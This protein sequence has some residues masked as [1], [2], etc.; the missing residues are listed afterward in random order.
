MSLIFRQLAQEL[1]DSN[2]LPM[3]HA[4]IHPQRY[5]V[6]ISTECGKPLTELNGVQFSRRSPTMAEINYAV[7]LLDAFLIKHGQTIRDA[8]KVHFELKDLEE[9]PPIKVIGYGD[10]YDNLE[11]YAHNT[12][13]IWKPK[14]KTFTV[15]FWRKSYE[16]VDNAT[17]DTKTKITGVAIPA[18]IKSKVRE[19]FK[20]DFHVKFLSQ[21]TEQLWMLA[22]KCDI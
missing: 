2:D 1:L 5:T 18:D 20:W 6:Q 17:W 21:K 9:H 4:D 22:N 16:I 8:I 11:L 19:Y 13:V 14:G 12:A 3:L 10:K 7:E 15:K